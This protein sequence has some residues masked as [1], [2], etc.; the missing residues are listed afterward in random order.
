VLDLFMPG[1]EDQLELPPI[2][3]DARSVS[4][5]CLLRKDSKKRRD[6][7]ADRLV[8]RCGQVRDKAQE[9]DTNFC[10]ISRYQTCHTSPG[11]GGRTGRPCSMNAANVVTMAAETP[12]N[13][14]SLPSRRCCRAPRS[15]G[16]G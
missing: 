8:D 13:D 7:A 10:R 6:Q 3:A 12:S 2:I 11:H 14:A 15:P 4:G 16:G 1:K 5:L 9:F